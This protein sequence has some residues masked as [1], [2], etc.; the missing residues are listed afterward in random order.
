M[1]NALEK[2]RPLP[3]QPL[4]V[5]EAELQGSQNALQMPYWKE[6][7]GSDLAVLSNHVA[8]AIERRRN[9]VEDSFNLLEAKRH[10]SGTTEGSKESGKALSAETELSARKRQGVRPCN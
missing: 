1:E 4:S 9:S 7:E 8:T 5:T 3:V 6:S 2:F 10:K